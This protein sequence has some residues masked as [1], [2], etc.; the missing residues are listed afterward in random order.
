MVSVGSSA[1]AGGGGGATGGGVGDERLK[2]DEDRKE[3]S[4]FVGLLYEG[5]GGGKGGGVKP[6]ATG[7][8]SADF[9]DSP[10]SHFI[11]FAVID[12]PV[13]STFVTVIIPPV[14]VA[15]IPFFTTLCFPFTLFSTSSTFISST[16]ISIF[17]IVRINV[18]LVMRN[19]ARS[20]GPSKMVA[21]RRFMVKLVH[22]CPVDDPDEEVEAEGGRS[23]D[24]AS[25]WSL[26][27]FQ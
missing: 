17:L 21:S 3:V 9:R 16:S 26:P 5:M 25:S 18:K 2:K 14:L 8:C 4:V 7:Q 24:R 11:T 15:F 19:R 27:S 12:I 10:E 22:G 23:P 1:G 6:V 13:A 20:R